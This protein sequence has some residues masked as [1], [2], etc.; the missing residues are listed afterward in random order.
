MNDWFTEFVCTNPVVRPPP[1][2][3]IRFP[4]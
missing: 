1:L 2:M 3:I 4:I